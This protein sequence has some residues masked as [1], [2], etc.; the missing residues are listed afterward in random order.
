ME[1][2]QPQTGDTVV[3]I[4]SGTGLLTLAFAERAAR[5]WA[6]DSS[7][8]MNEYLCAAAEQADSRT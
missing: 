1:L 2:A 6:I 5:V 8:A 7:P 3:D 4:G